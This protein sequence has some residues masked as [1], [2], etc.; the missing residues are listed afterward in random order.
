MLCGWFITLGVFKHLSHMISRCGTIQIGCFLSPWSHPSSGG[1][2]HVRPVPWQNAI[3]GFVFNGGYIFQ[4]GGFPARAFSMG[5]HGGDMFARRGSQVSSYQRGPS[6]V[7]SGTA[8]SYTFRDRPNEGSYHRMDLSM[9]RLRY[10]FSPMVAQIIEHAEKRHFHCFLSCRIPSLAI[11]SVSYPTWL[12]GLVLLAVRSIPWAI[13]MK[14]CR[15]PVRNQL[16]QKT[17]R[18][19]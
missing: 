19:L 18:C 17:I 7:I 9:I 14:T 5:V 11:L 8:I 4:L 12:T 15:Q 1:Q 10:Q 13:I 6:T 16:F 2:F 3:G